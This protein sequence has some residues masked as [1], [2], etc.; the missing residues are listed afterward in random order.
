MKNNKIGFALLVVATPLL[1]CSKYYLRQ[2][3]KAATQT[4]RQKKY[5]FRKDQVSLNCAFRELG[6][7]VHWAFHVQCLQRNLLKSRN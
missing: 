1:L 5:S 6:I 2:Q 7:N 3:V 4:V